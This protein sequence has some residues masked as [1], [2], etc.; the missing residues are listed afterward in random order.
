MAR[1][2]RGERKISQTETRKYQLRERKERRER[3]VLI[4]V[5]GP[6]LVFVVAI[7]LYGAYSEL[8]VKPRTPVARV[9]G[10]NISAEEFASRVAWMRPQLI[11]ELG[12]FMQF[13]SASDSSFLTNYAEGRRS[14]LPEDAR[15]QLIDDVLVRQ[16]AEARGIEVTSEDID[17]MIREDLESV[18]APPESEE[19]LVIATAGAEGTP[20]VTETIEITATA[21]IIPTQEIGSAFQR[22]VVDGILQ[23][24]E[25]TVS[26][27]RERVVKPQVYRDKLEEALGEELATSGPQVEAGNIRF[28]SQE[29]AERAVEAIE[30]GATWDDLIELYGPRDD[31]Q[32][33]MADLTEPETEATDSEDEAEGETTSAEAPPAGAGVDEADEV[34]EQAETDE[35]AESEEITDTLELT[36]TDEMTDT[37]ET[38]AV[39]EITD[40]GATTDTGEMGVTSELTATLDITPTAT[41]APTLTPAPTP[42][43]DPY[44]FGYDEAE[45]LTRFGIVDGWGLSDEDAD[46]IFDLEPVACSGPYQ[47]GESTW[48]VVCVFDAEDDRE[49]DEAELETR[50]EQSL[51]DWLEERREEAEVDKF[52]LE[53]V[54]PPEPLW[55]TQAMA[56]YVQPQPTLDLE[57][58]E[59]STTAPDE[60]GAAPEEPVDSAGGEESVGDTGDDQSSD[61]AAEEQPAQGTGEEEPLEGSARDEPSDEGGEG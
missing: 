56:E 32:A 49:I 3:Q 19:P 45:W 54:T 23:Q 4:A 52:P 33:A 6:V 37:G 36:D 29:T 46:E 13:A 53:E 1:R 50:R 2:R 34:L 8:Y 48:Y 26:E 5:L 39:G 57:S 35:V 27:Y 61:D 58:I 11:S 24:A 42:T 47:V 18:I 20:A 10:E 43:P 28:T 22:Y 21:T 15:T 9:E 38:G 25:M 17:R 60:S 16:E 40:T 41:P 55:F 44:A 12:S 14:S 59:V 30:S 31:E 51:T 7:L